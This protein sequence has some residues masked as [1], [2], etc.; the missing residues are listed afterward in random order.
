MID[1][2]RGLAERVRIDAAVLLDG[3]RQHFGHEQVGVRR[4]HAD[5]GGADRDARLHLVEL[6]ADHLDHRRQLRVEPLLVGEPDRDRIGVEDVVHVRA[7]AF[8]QLL[9]HAIA[10]AVADQRRELQPLLARLAQQAA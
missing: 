9:V 10:G 5:M 6:L 4:G 7:E 3:A 8:L 1:F 2:Q